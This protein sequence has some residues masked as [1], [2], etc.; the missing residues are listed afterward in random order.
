MNHIRSACA[1]FALA[2]IVPATASAAT[3][4]V[5]IS[6]DP[7]AGAEVTFTAT[8]SSTAERPVF[9]TLRPDDG[10]PCAATY[11]AEPDDRRL[12]LHDRSGAVETRTLDAPGIWL[13]CA[14]AYDDRDAA[15]SGTQALTFTVRAA[16]AHLTIEAPTQSVGEGRVGVAVTGFSEIP[17]GVRVSWRRADG[18]PCAASP[19]ADAGTNI[20]LDAAGRATG[21]F[22]YAGSFGH[23]FGLDPGVHT[24]CAWLV[25]SGYDTIAQATATVRILPARPRL[26]PISLTVSR[27]EAAPYGGSRFDHPHLGTTVTVRLNV[28]ATVR[29]GV[30]RRVGRRWVRLRG[31]FEVRSRPLADYHA[32]S[33]RLRNRALRPGRYQLLAT[34]RNV[35]GR[36]TTRRHAFRILGRQ[37]PG[38]GFD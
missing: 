18:T 4:D 17:A 5:Q 36:S 31:T 24:L 9:A 19:F 10:V 33:G 21:P 20:A 11:D 37:H 13:I 6:P 1:L 38:P 8:S 23:V 28:P 7:V 25:D 26:A 2:L 16:R 29:F 22:R 32:F 15:P 12:F 35:S 34:A 14:Y 27:F 3:V 30:R